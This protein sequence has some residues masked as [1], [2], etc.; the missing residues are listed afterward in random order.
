[1]TIEVTSSLGEKNILF[2]KVPNNMMHLWQPLDISV[3]GWVKRWMRK[4]FEDMYAEQIRT[5]LDN[6]LQLESIEVKVTFILMK[7]VMLD[8]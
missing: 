7:H 3:N 1:M 2:V 4:R 8:G 5:G 6:S